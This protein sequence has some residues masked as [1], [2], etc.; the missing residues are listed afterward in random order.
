MNIRAW[1][2]DF[3][4]HKI[5]IPSCKSYMNVAKEIIQSED[6]YIQKDDELHFWMQAFYK[7]NVIEDKETTEASLATTE[8]DIEKKYL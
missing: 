6:R 1:T 8:E 5:L 3:S 4:V 7:T 2:E